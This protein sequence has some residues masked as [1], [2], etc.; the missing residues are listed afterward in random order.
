MISEFI[1]ISK[2][3]LTAEI[4]KVMSVESSIVSTFDLAVSLTLA[5]V[6]NAVIVCIA[7]HSVRWLL[8]R[9]PALGSR[10]SF[11]G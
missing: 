10:A 11:C 1:E 4:S 6:P 3:L 7:E 9:T 5:A 2:R 8:G